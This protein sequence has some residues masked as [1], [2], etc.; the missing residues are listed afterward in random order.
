MGE[1]GVYE[2]I[3]GETS[4]SPQCET[5]THLEPVNIYL[6]EFCLPTF[7]LF[8]QINQPNW[9]V[10]ILLVFFAILLFAVCWHGCKWLGRKYLSNSNNENEQ[11]MVGDRKMEKKRMRSI[12]AFRGYVYSVKWKCNIF[13]KLLFAIFTFNECHYFL[14]AFCPTWMFNFYPLRNY[15]TTLYEQFVP[16]ECFI[17]FRY[18]S[19]LAPYLITASDETERLSSSSSFP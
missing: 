1:F 14:C 11:P 3:A 8:L 16:L 9:N 12:D 5:K 13:W 18:A 7:S 6:R 15:V 17:F 2:I 10:A 19:H 4:G